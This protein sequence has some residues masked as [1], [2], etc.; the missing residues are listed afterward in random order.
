MKV[1]PSII[2][3]QKIIC[4]LGVVMKPYCR[5]T[6]DEEQEEEERLACTFLYMLRTLK[7][8]TFKTT[9]A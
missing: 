9:T 2:F 5:V 4:Q 1:N 7:P 6:V 3:Y 8:E